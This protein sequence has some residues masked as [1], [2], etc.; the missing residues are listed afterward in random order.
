VT[1]HPVFIL[2]AMFIGSIILSVFER[3]AAMA[4]KKT[5]ATKKGS[6]PAAADKPKGKSD[7]AFKQAVKGLTGAW[8]KARTVDLGKGDFSTPD[9]ED[10]SYQAQLTGMQLG[11]F[12]PQAA[13]GKKGSDGFRPATPASLWVSFNFVI[14]NGDYAGTKV[15]RRDVLSNPDESPDP[16]RAQKNLNNFVKNLKGLCGDAYDISA[17]DIDADL[18]DLAK[19]LSKDKPYAQLGISNW[20]SERDP[21]KKGI[22]VYINKRLTAADVE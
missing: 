13:K 2:F 1:F 19:D 16:E 14:K 20:T 22:N 17:L 18:E 8:K 4:V 21:D 11:A 10:G 3:D 9:I 12:K 5:T 6:A 7:P 15:R